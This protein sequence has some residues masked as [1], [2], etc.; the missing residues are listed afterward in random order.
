MKKSI[1]KFCPILAGLA[2]FCFFL[3]LSL[4]CNCVEAQTPSE[5]DVLFQ[6]GFPDGYAAEFRKGIKWEDYFEK[7]EPIAY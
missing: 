2:A 5:P 6:I 1:L 7:D 4:L 3:I